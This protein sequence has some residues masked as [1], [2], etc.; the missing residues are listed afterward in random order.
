[1]CTFKPS[2]AVALSVVRK[3]L[4][5]R[6]SRVSLASRACAHAA[7][8]HDRA[9]HRIAST[10]IPA[11]DAVRLDDAVNLL[12]RQSRWQPLASHRRFDACAQFLRTLPALEGCRLAS[13]SSPR[14]LRSGS[15]RNSRRLV[16][17]AI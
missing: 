10:L 15:R 14:L 3:F 17:L 9:R 6:E 4:R 1:M 16:S 8:T 5:Y 13:K 11:D 7:L 2:V 12:M